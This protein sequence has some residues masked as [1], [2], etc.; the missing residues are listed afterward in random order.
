M[1]FDNCYYTLFTTICA[2][3]APWWHSN[4]LLLTEFTL[5]SWAWIAAL[6]KTFYWRS[7]C[8][9]M[10]IGWNDYWQILLNISC[11]NMCPSCTLL[12]F[13]LT[14]SCRVF[15]FQLGIVCSTLEHIL[16]PVLPTDD[17]WCSPALM[18]LSW[19]CCWGRPVPL[20]RKEEQITPEKGEGEKGAWLD[21]CG[22]L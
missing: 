18:S 13:P 4:W 21:W 8:Q 12:A 5:S 9:K 10:V 22:L 6:W 19:C 2:L 17:Y 3:P 1:T 7:F 20:L 15:P 14:S 16:N 11:Y